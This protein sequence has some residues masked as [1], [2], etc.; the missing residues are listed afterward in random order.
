[1]NFVW[2]RYAS[3]RSMTIFRRVNPKTENVVNYLAE[4]RQI[5]NN[6]ESSRGKWP[7]QNKHSRINSQ[8]MLEFL[9]TIR[10]FKRFSCGMICDVL[11]HLPLGGVLPSSKTIDFSFSDARRM[12]HVLFN[13]SINQLINSFFLLRR[14]H[15]ID[16]HSRR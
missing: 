15:I 16:K 11:R 3:L 2:L 5:R 8:E 9:Q 4:I 14:R 1:M 12:G 10:C 13:E 6:K 7:I